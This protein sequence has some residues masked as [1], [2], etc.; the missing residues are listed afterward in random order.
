MFVVVY[1][2]DSLA[3]GRVDGIT[4]PNGRT[5]RKVRKVTQRPREEWIGIPVP[6]CDMPREWVDAARKAVGGNRRAPST[7]RR[8]WE[9]SGGLLRCAMCGGKMR[10]HSSHGR[11]STEPRYFYYRCGT[12]WDNG[13]CPHNK[14]HRA[15]DTEHLV[16]ESVR[17]LLGDPERF[18]ADLE[19]MI[20]ME[21]AA[22]RG[23]PDREARTW[24]V[25]LAE[26]DRKRS[27]YLDLAAE[28]IMDRD[29]LMEK[30]SALEE[31]RKRAEGE[32]EALRSRQ[33]RLEVLE[34][35]KGGPA[36][37]LRTDD[38]GSS[39]QPY[40]REA[41]PRLRHARPK[42]YDCNGRDDGG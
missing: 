41:P 30:L 42:G 4:G 20:E 5:Y 9:L 37:I 16:W 23:D 28:G 6:D 11:G 27:G 31:L 3:V 36:R 14:Q 19:R 35:D 39:R 38:T 10:G 26:A 18:R 8:F 7:N 24:H 40:A 13:S 25:K 32:L 1:I 15:E 22:T 21:R 29:E 2:G 17:G 34:R 33:E 12:Q